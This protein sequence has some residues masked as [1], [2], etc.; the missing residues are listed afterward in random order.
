MTKFIQRRRSSKL[1][2]LPLLS[3]FVTK[4]P[5]SKQLGS[6]DNRV[7]IAKDFLDNINFVTVADE[8]LTV[9]LQEFQSMFHDNDLA[10]LSK[11]KTDDL[12]RYVEKIKE[13]ANK[14][15]EL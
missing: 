12:Q 15:N 4:F 5:F 14:F 3:C 7:Q 6:F 9:F 10:F 13:N 8:T 2:K 11:R 1:L